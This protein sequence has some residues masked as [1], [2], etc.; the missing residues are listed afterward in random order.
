MF[1]KVLSII[2]IIPMFFM[3]ISCNIKK[4]ENESKDTETKISTNLHEYKES[5]EVYKRNGIRI[6]YPV[7]KKLGDEKKE[8]KI[9]SE[10]KKSALKVLD[11]YIEDE[12]I[13]L[14]IIYEVNLKNEK[15]FSVSFYGVGNIVNA[16]YQTNH[17]YTINIDMNTG[18]KL[19]LSD[20]IDVNK[21]LATKIKSL[22]FEPVQDINNDDMKRIFETMNEDSILESLEE[23]DSL[24]K[25]STGKQ[26]DYFSYITE[27]S[28]GISIR[29][30]HAIGDHIEFETKYEDIGFKLK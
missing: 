7:I 21:E 29:V 10:I 25:I 13:E 26:F 17:F 4:N 2:I 11:Y 3:F 1:K 30:P 16:S 27:D 9:N 18:E 14:D 6:S 24:D 23:S 22:D 12:E 5:S 15:F 19:I 28:I 20:M 8:Y